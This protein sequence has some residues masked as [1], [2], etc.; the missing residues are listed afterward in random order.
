MV[1]REGAP[2]YDR[3]GEEADGADGGAAGFDGGRVA[4]AE[5]AVEA[6]AALFFLFVSGD[7]RGGGR[8]NCG[9]SEEESAD[10]GAEFSGDQ[11]GGDGDHTA[12]EETDG[13]LLP[14]ALLQGREIYFYA[15]GF[16]GVTSMKRTGRTVAGPD[17]R[18]SVSCVFFASERAFPS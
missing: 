2:D 16:I 10:S 5:R 9:E 18:R 4:S 12:E 15:H 17:E 1:I 13:V 11:A 8:E 3:E 14:G 7:Q 6:G